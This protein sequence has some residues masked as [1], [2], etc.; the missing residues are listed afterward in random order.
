[1]DLFTHVLIGYLLALGATGFQPGY[2]AAGAIAGGL[3]DGDVVF[4]LLARRFPMFRH[5][6]ITHS[7]F[8]VTLV[9]LVGAFLAPRIL[10]GSPLLYFL[11]MELAGLGHI[12]GDAFT[13]FS[14]AP[15]LPFSNRP[16]QID[17][18]RAI[19][20]LTLGV[21][22]GALVVLSS[23]RFHVAFGVYL[24][25]VYLLAAFYATYFAIRLTGRYRIGVIRKG[26]PEFTTP[27]P[28]GNPLRWLLVYERREDGRLRSGVAQ[29]RLGRGL[30]GAILR[31]DV[32]LTD[33][34]TGPVGSADEAL[35]RSYP[36][37]REANSVLD[38][39]YHT[40]Q[41]MAREG[42]GWLV[43]WYS[44][45]FAAFGRASGV[46]VDIDPAGAVQA[47]SGWLPTRGLWPRVDAEP[48][49]S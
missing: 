15:L 44:L 12:A 22:V 2:L 42:G 47:H 30:V 40:G 14:V 31:V 49:S 9:A 43:R 3:P 19:N 4:F 8:G 24:A 36:A 1:M 11:V 16:L 28:T 32:P 10:P 41:A 37:A 26:L 35:S 23:E 29:Y 25:S 48:R 5:H 18:D 46:R 39:T 34:G 20:F 17:A 7:V 45:E 6:G 27:I 33:A 13:H 38:G 21:S